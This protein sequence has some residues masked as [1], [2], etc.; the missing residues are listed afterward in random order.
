MGAEGFCGVVC[1]RLGYSRQATYLVG[2]L[3]KMLE[4][5][6]KVLKYKAFSFFL[7]LLSQLVM[8]LSYLLFNILV[9][10]NKG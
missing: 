3:I 10:K 4:N 1:G 6:A 5:N 7:P 8:M 2:P 9:S